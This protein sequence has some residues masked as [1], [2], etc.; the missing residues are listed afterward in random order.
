MLRHGKK[1]RERDTQ[2]AKRIAGTNGR[3]VAVETGSGQ[4]VSSKAHMHRG[5]ADAQRATEIQQIKDLGKAP[6]KTTAWMKSRDLGEL[7][8][9]LKRRRQKSNRLRW[10]GIWA[11]VFQVQRH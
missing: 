10:M 5:T 9:H 3:L 6:D 2:K 8:D 7:E 11:I 1:S 4:R